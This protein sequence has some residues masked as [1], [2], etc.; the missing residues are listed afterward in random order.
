MR[1]LP[2]QPGKAPAEPVAHPSQASLDREAA[3]ETEARI[4]IPSEEIGQWIDSW[5]TPNPLPMPTPRK[6]V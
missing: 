4:G 3:A 5:G 2:M 6:V 1:T